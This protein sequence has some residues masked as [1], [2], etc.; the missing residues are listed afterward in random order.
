MISR[1]DNI[2]TPS[3]PTTGRSDVLSIH[4]IDLKY[5]FFIR[6]VM[7]PYVKEIWSDRLNVLLAYLKIQF[8]K[9]A[10]SFNSEGF[11]TMEV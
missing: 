9:M 2:P 7:Q 4:Y 6:K 10:S 1:K 8:S 5:H 3:E 11:M